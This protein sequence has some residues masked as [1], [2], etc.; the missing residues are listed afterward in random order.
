[1]VGKS[2]FREVSDIR[3][4]SSIREGSD[5]GEALTLESG[6][7]LERVPT[8]SEAWTPLGLFLLDLKVVT[9]TGSYWAVG[10]SVF[11]EVSGFRE[12]SD[13]FR[14]FCFYYLK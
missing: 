14:T 3:E 1:M 12:V 7:T 5:S 2:V 13:F 8:S 4:F 9:Y 10:K 11:R 6:L